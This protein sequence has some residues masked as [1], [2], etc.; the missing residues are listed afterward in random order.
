MKPAAFQ[1]L[2]QA[3]TL[4]DLALRGRCHYLSKTMEFFRVQ[5]PH[6]AFRMSYEILRDQHPN[7]YVLKNELLIWL[8]SHTTGAFIQTEFF[9]P[10]RAIDVVV[11]SDG[12]GTAYEIKTRYD[13]TAKLEGQIADYSKVFDQVV[14]VTQNGYSG[15]FHRVVPDWVGLIVLG[16]RGP[17]M[18]RK[19][20]RYTRNLDKYRILSCMRKAE[21]VAF[22]KDVDPSRKFVP[23]Y[24]AS[25]SRAIAMDLSP[26]EMSEYF[27]RH[28]HLRE[29]PVRHLECISMLP[30]CFVAALYDYWFTLKDLGALRELMGRPI[31]HGEPQ[32]V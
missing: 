1:I 14:L 7:E 28:L 15:K 30:D 12:E 32:P 29:R 17:V 13:S 26:M 11:V 3:Q 25:Q 23:T 19:P 31:D 22:V 5:Y 16:P 24:Y 9:C 4:R 21:R 27:L 2:F 6:E 20:K 8:R 18:T 10:E